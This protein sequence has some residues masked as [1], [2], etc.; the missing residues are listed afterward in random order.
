MLVLVSIIKP[1]IYLYIKGNKF[2]FIYYV[3]GHIVPRLT[4]HYKCYFDRDDF[5]MQCI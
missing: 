4:R 2:Y 1:N 5:R 3:N